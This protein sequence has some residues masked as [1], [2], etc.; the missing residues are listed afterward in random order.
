MKLEALES[1]FCRSFVGFQECHGSCK[2]ILNP[3]R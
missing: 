3:F 1:R 2:E